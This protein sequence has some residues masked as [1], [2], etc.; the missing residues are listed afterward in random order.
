MIK[1]LL[2]DFSWVILHP[3]DRTY[4]GKLNDL[5]RRMAGD[6]PLAPYNFK[7][8]FTINQELLDYI[9][10]LKAQYDLGIYMFTT[11]IIQERSEVQVAIAG[12]FDRIFTARELVEKGISQQDYDA[13]KTDSKSFQYI[14]NELHLNPQAILYIDDKPQ[15]LRAAQEAGLQTVLYTKAP[16]MVEA[17]TEFFTA[18]KDILHYSGD[19]KETAKDADNA[20]TLASYA[21]N[22]PGYINGTPHETVDGVKVWLDTALAMLPKDS[23][24][25]EVGAG[26]GR[27]TEYLKSLHFHATPTDAIDEFVDAMK[28]RGHT[29]AYKLD[30]LTDKIPA[31][32]D[33]ILADAVL[34]HFNDQ[35]AKTI[36]AHFR[37][38][39]K[40]GG[41]LAASIKRGTGEER[42]TDKLGLPRFFHYW[43]P[44]DFKQLLAESGFTIVYE[45]LDS[46]GRN[47]SA[48]FS[49]IAKPW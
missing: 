21:A 13:T 40:S 41:I 1:A 2:L 38:A 22:V 14:A 7:Q 8:H 4:E 49:I 25:L 47:N 10:T 30:L 20:E 28:E 11:D 24:I 26:F 31:G 23:T 45:S 39:L 35:Q 44:D 16:T 43:S 37:E 19:K 3:A 17:N 34:L 32:Q 33:M 46:T 42:V 18:I 48:W 12:L 5:N 27:R 6:D 36:L 15:N 9:K 29:N